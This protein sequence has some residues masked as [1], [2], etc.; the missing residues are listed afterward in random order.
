MGREADTSKPTFFSIVDTGD[1]GSV[2][3]NGDLEVGRPNQAAPARMTVKSSV[4]AHLSSMSLHEDSFIQVIPGS[5]QMGGVVFGDK[6][7]GRQARSL[8]HPSYCIM[9]GCVQLGTCHY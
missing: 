1:Y 9:R 6:M 2:L 7:T 3:L 5:N 8:T 4:S